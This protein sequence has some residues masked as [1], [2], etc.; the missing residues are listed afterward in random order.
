MAV[1]FGTKKAFVDQR[2]GEDTWVCAAETERGGTAWEAR[3]HER[4]MVMAK[5]LLIPIFA[6]RLFKLGHA[7]AHDED[8]VAH[9][10]Q[11]G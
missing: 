10:W 8:T 9:C 7:N 2:Q 11:G 4:G 1:P 6:T 5:S 3:R